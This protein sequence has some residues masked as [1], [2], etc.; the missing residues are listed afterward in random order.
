MGSKVFENKTPLEPEAV[1]VFGEVCVSSQGM[2]FMNYCSAR[3]PRLQP[4]VAHE[5]LPYLELLIR[6]LMSP[7]ITGKKDRFPYFLSSVAEAQPAGE[8][9]GVGSALPVTWLLGHYRGSGLGTSPI[10]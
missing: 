7:G 10:I 3:M 8:G 4:V 5:L 2:E 1:C 9:S 6:G